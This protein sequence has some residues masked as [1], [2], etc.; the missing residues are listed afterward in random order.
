MERKRLRTRTGLAHLLLVAALGAGMSG[1]CSNALDKARSA[2]ADGEGDLVEAEPLYKEA[3]GQSKTKDEAKAELVAIYCKLAR[4]L[5]KGKAKEADALYA[6]ALEIEPEHEEALEGRARAL[7][8][9]QMPDKALEVVEPVALKGKCRACK[10]LLAVLLIDRGD[11]WAHAGYLEQAEADYDRSLQIIPNATVALQVA[12]IRISRK[13]TQ[14]AADALEPAAVLIGP[15]DTSAREQF[16][17]MRKQVVLMALAEDKPE[18]ADKLLDLAPTGVGAD[19]QAAL[20]LDVAGE[21]RKL[22]KPDMAINRLEGMV[23][24]DKQG[25]LKVSAQRKADMFDKLISLYVGRSSAKLA[26]G[27]V[28]GSDADLA[29]AL[30]VRP[31]DPLLQLQ[32]VL[33][34]A[35]SGDLTKAQAALESIDPK[36][37]GYPQVFAILT[38][39]H[40]HDLIKAGRFEAARSELAKAKS[41]AP[42]LPEVHIATAALLVHT[43]F[44]P[45]KKADARELVTSG[46]VKYDKK[47]TRLAEALSEID[48]SRQSI[49]ALGGSYPYRGPGT[50]VR[51]SE[52]EA[53]IKAM[54]PFAVKFN[55][56][57]KT[58]VVLENKGSDTVSARLLCKWTLAEAKV[59]PGQSQA[60]PPMPPGFCELTHGGKRDIF[61]A[62]PYT[63]VKIPI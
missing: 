16:L 15:A 51:M 28:T 27:D 61:V 26:K 50:D 35:G 29:R 30:E 49:A 7:M 22:G 13:N 18:L 21:A 33:T 48:W 41:R 11:R 53:K 32:R 57:A 8:A 46:I 3:I 31:G 17:E 62:E 19:E 25:K 14:G 4:P 44:L 10:R 43:E 9:R 40:V 58:V 5:I 55:A 52:L 37:Q 36:T 39:M 59:A 54:V 60:L 34:S 23:E 47:V 1:G 45:L 12:R 20:A 38:S 6:K 42:D 63:E 2:W 56:A 24:A